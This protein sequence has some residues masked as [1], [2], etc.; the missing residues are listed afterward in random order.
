MTCVYLNVCFFDKCNL[1]AIGVII[2]VTSVLLIDL[3]SQM[4][5]VKSVGLGL[6]SLGRMCPTST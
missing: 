3:M 6:S 2:S 5:I 4:H 1:F